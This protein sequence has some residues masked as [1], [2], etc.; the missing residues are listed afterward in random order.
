MNMHELHISL[1]ALCEELSAIRTQLLQLEGNQAT[2][3]A[4]DKQ[5]EKHKARLAY[6]AGQLATLTIEIEHTDHILTEVTN[7]N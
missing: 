5:W 6:L 3:L 4:W 1:T 2:P 7:G